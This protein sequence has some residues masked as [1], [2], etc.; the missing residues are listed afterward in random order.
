MKPDY[1]KGKWVCEKAC[2]NLIAL[3][4]ALIKGLFTCMYCG[5]K[6]SYIPDK[7]ITP[8]QLQ[9]RFGLQ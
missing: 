9:K 8:Q 2:K 3:N 4:V 6:V 1:V 7:M 5:G